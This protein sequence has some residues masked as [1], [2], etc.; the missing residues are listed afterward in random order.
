MN[1]FREFCLKWFIKN[2][3]KWELN[4]IFKNCCTKFKIKFLVVSCAVKSLAVM[5]PRGNSSSVCYEKVYLLF[6]CK[7]ISSVMIGDIMKNKN[8][9]CKFSVRDKFLMMYSNRGTLL[10]TFDWYLIHIIYKYKVVLQMILEFT[11]SSSK[12]TNDFYFICYQ[13]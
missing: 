6:D 3:L 1:T 5:S 4:L 11:K 10:L 2:K 8:I 13:F 12:L 9:C 7:G